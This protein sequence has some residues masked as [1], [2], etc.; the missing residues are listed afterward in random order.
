MRLPT[1]QDG[2]K[3]RDKVYSSCAHVEEELREKRRE[4]SQEKSLKARKKLGKNLKGKEKVEKGKIEHKICMALTGLCRNRLSLNPYHLR[5]WWE[6]ESQG[7]LITR[8]TSVY[9]YNF[10]L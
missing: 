9:I 6:R 3:N 4:K 10:N 7:V 8:S 5:K 1:R 2:V